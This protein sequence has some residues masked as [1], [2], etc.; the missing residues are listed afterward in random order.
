MRL[1]G[2]T[3]NKFNFWRFYLAFGLPLVVVYLLP[4]G[5]EGLQSVASSLT[6]VAFMAALVL[7]L[8]IHRPEYPRVWYLLTA[9]LLAFV[10]G[11]VTYG[12][13]RIVLGGNPLP[14]AADIFYLAGYALIGAALM[15]SARR[16]NLGGD[17]TSYIDAAIIATS[18]GM[19]TWTFLAM[20][21]LQESGLSLPERSLLTAYPLID[22]LLLAAVVRF[23]ATPGP[24]APAYYLASLGMA[25]LLASDLLFYAANLTGAF[26]GETTVMDAGYLLSYILWGAAALHP[27]MRTLSEPAPRRRVQPSLAR[28]GVLAGVLLLGPV[29]LIVQVARGTPTNVPVIVV[30]SVVLFSLVLIRMEG[31]LGTLARALEQRERAE[32]ELR[33]GEARFRSLVQN[34]SDLIV[35]VGTEGEIRYMSPASRPVLGYDPEEL[36]GTAAMQHLHPEDATWASQELAGSRWPAEGGETI[37]T[38]TVRVR[39]K[40]GSWRHL[41][42]VYT[43]LLDE[44]SVRGFVS[45]LRDVTERKEAEEAL[46]QSERRFRQLFEQSVDMFFVHDGDG[47]IFDCNQAACHALGYSRE[48]L[49]SL[50]I[51]HLD[52]NVLSEEERKAREADGGT[53]W[54]RAL[55]GDPGTQATVVRTELRRKDGTMFPAEVRVGGVDY[56]GQRMILASARDVSERRRLENRLAHQATHD[57]LTDLPNRRLFMEHL[58]RAL[59]RSQRQ[60]TKVAVLFVDLDDFKQANDDLGHEAGDHLLV[61]VAKRL[62]GCLRSA[63]TVARLGGDEFV[64]VL[65]DISDE[66]AAMQ[67][68]ERIQRVLCSPFELNGQRISL[69]ASVGV[70]FGKPGADGALQ[71]ENLLRKADAAMYRIKKEGKNRHE[72]PHLETNEGHPKGV[73]TS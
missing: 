4:L 25:V 14:S 58:E 10:L 11:D 7:G 9:G 32:K 44:P 39:H 55:A 69:A 56:G 40:D 50:T 21:Y 43:D 1:E 22:V 5:L 13:Y 18:A 3:L 61:A 28:L 71:A 34:A 54:Q 33:E 67:N 20:P 47:C 38:G 26:E 52:P 31:L 73:E 17:R 62:R 15:L 53:P 42:W 2:V 41:E 57:P 51:Q 46:K 45:N 63:D 16:R 72:T 59:K 66:A 29:L 48:E 23:V 27:S 49:L 19:L 35:V 64:V 6:V 60:G 68:V 65:E 36:V 24:R 8:R 37:R 70:A 30:G 12:F